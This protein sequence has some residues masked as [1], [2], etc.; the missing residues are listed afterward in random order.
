MIE[1][2]AYVAVYIFVDVQCNSERRT[3][4]SSHTMVHFLKTSNRQYYWCSPFDFW[5]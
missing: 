5:W 1:I 2:T 4:D 3:I